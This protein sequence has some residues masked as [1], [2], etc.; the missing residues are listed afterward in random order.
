MIMN[1]F[2][3]FINKLKIDYSKYQSRSAE[4]TG[5][6]LIG[7]TPHKGRDTWHHEL[8]SPLT[9]NQ[10]NSLETQCKTTFHGD[11]RNFFSTTNGIRLFSD[12][13]AI[14]GLRG[15][16]KRKGDA[17]WQ[18]YSIVEP[19]SIERPAGMPKE[20]TIIG[21]YSY[22]GSLLWMGAKLGNIS[23]RSRE[24]SKALIA[25]WKDLSTFLVAEYKRLKKYFGDSLELI[26]EDISTLPVQ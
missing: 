22:D 10:I 13:I 5:A 16:F 18:P 19:N 21:S 11:L 1:K 17:I 20:D 7:Q 4:Q 9:K 24:N 8:F 23:L 14:Y 25:E 2:E 12:E 6:L 3:E 26:D 15:N